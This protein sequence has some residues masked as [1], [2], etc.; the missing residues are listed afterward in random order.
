MSDIKEYTRGSLN[1]KHLCDTLDYKLR[2]ARENPD[3]FYPSGIWLATG[4]Q[5]AGKTLTIVQ[6]AQKMAADYPKAKIASNMP[7]YGFDREIIPFTTYEDLQLITNGLNGVIIVLDEFQVWYNCK[8]S[9]DI[10]IEEIACFCQMRKDRRIILSTSQVYKRVA[11]DIREQM[12]Y[13]IDCHN[14]FNVMQ[15]NTIMDPRTG[16]EVDGHVSGD[17]VCHRVWFHSP[18][19]Y[20]MYETLNKIERPD[21]KLP[22]KGVRRT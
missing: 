21:R 19:L 14:L 12:S 22:K 7:L 17:I 20:A 9:K 5:G 10:P 15:I 18:E 13:I 2:F 1:P 3:Y 6:I 11:I 8:V 4:P 16:K